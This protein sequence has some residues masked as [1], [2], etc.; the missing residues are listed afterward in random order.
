MS[1]IVS[2]ILKLAHFSKKGEIA[3]INWEYSLSSKN[4]AGG[5]VRVEV[6]L[7]KRRENPNSLNC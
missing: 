1:Q 3:A 4:I 7:Q 6:E 5:M 2:A